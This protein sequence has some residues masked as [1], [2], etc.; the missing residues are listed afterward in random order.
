MYCQQLLINVIIL[1][2]DPTL[3]TQNGKLLI[4]L[5]T[6]FQLEV[7]F[8]KSIVWGK[9]WYRHTITA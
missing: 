5:W 9:Q 7:I 8:I 1:S 4:I 3:L 2:E 6:R